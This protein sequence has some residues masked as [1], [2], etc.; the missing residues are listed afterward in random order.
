MSIASPSAERRAYS[1]KGELERAGRAWRTN[2][3]Q[4]PAVT[5]DAKPD[6]GKSA[7]QRPV[8]VDKSDLSWNEV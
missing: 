3:Y 5:P 6:T 7:Q 2:F 1:R 4:S 8:L